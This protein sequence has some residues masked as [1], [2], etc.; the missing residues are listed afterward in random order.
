MIGGL[1]DGP[2]TSPQTSSWLRPRA[3]EDS[4]AGQPAKNV[5]YR[6]RVQSLVKIWHAIRFKIGVVLGGVYFLDGSY[7][8][9]GFWDQ[10]SL[11]SDLRP[12]GFFR[13]P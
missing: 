3:I 8:A 6:L 9:L 5:A 13:G 7:F 12:L 1:K 2:A 11:L 4:D 10:P